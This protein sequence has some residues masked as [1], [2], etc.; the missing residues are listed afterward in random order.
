MIQPSEELLEQWRHKAR[1]SCYQ[2][3]I[4]LEA[5]AWAESWS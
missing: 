3:P 1:A 2:V 4:A 5:L